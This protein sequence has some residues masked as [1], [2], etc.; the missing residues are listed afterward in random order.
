MADENGILSKM[1]YENRTLSKMADEKGKQ[2][3]KWTCYFVKNVHI[4]NCTNCVPAD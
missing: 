1:A 4:K 3:L 2:T